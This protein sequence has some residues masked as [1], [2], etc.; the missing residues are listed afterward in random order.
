MIRFSLHCDKGHE[1]ESWFAT[2]GEYDMLRKRGLVDCPECGSKKVEKSLM[3]P[4]VS[5][6][7]SKEKV[8]VM[9]ADA[10]N[11]VMRQMQEL[12]RKVRTEA[13]NVGDKFAEEARKIHYGESDPRGI[14]GKA[15]R[16]EVESLAEEGVPFLPLPD[17]PEDA[18]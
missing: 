14:Y 12:A 10:R 3:A 7:R 4:A 11:E 16:D 8:A 17:L 13:D 1:F 5:T 9:A 15:T 6:S 18:N 2:G